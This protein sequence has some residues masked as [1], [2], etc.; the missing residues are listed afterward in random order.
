MRRQGAACVATSTGTCGL[1][2]SP[3]LPGQN[4]GS[5][6]VEQGEIGGFNGTDQGPN[7]GAVT[8][9]PVSVY[10]EDRHPGGPGCVW[11]CGSKGRGP[12]SGALL[13]PGSRL[14]AE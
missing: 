11:G 7:E 2:R 1:Q 8:A 6:S 12:F 5:R 10:W 3:D 4:T 13:R 9:G 14:R